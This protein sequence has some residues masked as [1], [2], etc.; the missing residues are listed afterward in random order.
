MSARRRRRQDARTIW[1]YGLRLLTEFRWTILA[2]V[3][4]VLVG[5]TLYAVTP[6]A[7]LGGRRPGLLTSLYGAW[8]AMFAQP[9]FLPETWYLAILSG[10][11]PLLG[12]VL[13]GEGIVRFGLLMVSRRRG[14]KEWMK[15]MASTYRNHV[16]LCGVGRLGIRV[17]EQ[18]LELREQ[19]VV[20]EKDPA[21]KGVP[22]ARAT[23]VPVIIRDMTEDDSLVEAG[24]P[25]A[26]VIILAT[27]DDLANLEV[28]LD[29]RRLNPGIR[30]A[31]RL[32]DQKLAAKL[33][34]AFGVDVAFSSS[35]LAAP[36]VAAM[37]LG[38]RVL[39][40]FP[41]AGVPTC[42]AELRVERASF[43]VGMT[44]A[45][46][47]AMH[48]IR[49]LSR[50]RRGEHDAHPAATTALEPGDVIIVHAPTAKLATLTAATRTSRTPEDVRVES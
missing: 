21:S 5:A 22:M 42:A 6:Q 50:T 26:R 14:E 7:A 18:L 32:F 44:I 15:V 45:D 30:V 38:P 1:L 13:I 34:S 37:A 27:S 23:G 41:L 33:T 28:A 11:Y 25:H 36:A 3:L 20:L 9:I 17:L 31:M 8:M 43:M 24:V 40:S 49:V 12:F 39:A 10:V 48:G 29:A 46:V 16:V 19:V 4:A 2:I 47:E 35:A